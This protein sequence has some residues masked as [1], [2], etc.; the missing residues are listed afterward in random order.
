MA[1]NTKMNGHT[2]LDLPWHMVI[3]MVSHEL[4]F[5]GRDIY[6]LVIEAEI[7]RLR[8]LRLLAEHDHALDDLTLDQP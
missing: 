4:G 7:D 2:E 6:D 3:D 8:G 1:K 5:A